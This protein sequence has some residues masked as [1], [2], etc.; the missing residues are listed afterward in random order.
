MKK[1]LVWMLVLVLL[2]GMTTVSAYAEAATEVTLWTLFTGDDG[3]TLQKI[4]DDFNASQTAVHLNHEAI[5]R[6]TLY[7]KLALSMS[8]EASL[9]DFFVTY[10]Y[11]VPYFA[12][13]DY[14][15]PMDET[16][17]AYGDFDFGFDKYHDACAQLNTFNG[18]R[19]CV[20]LDFPT[21]G[22]YAN[23]NLVN[24]YCPEVLEDD[25][26]TWDEIKAVGDKLKTDGVSD[27][28]VMVSSWA[29]ND[30]LASYLDWAGTYANEEGTEL[31]L[32]KEAAAEML[33]VWND[34]YN[35]GYLQQEGDDAGTLFATE[36]AIF[37]TGGTWNMTAINQYGFDFRFIA[38]PQKDT[39]G[40]PVL[41]GA[42]H[43]FM[44][45]KKNESAETQKGVSAF[46]HYFYEHS[47]DWASAGSIVAS[48]ATAASD[49]Y[50]AMAQA[51]V[52]NNYS[53][54]LPP[55][56]YSQLLFDV[57]DSLGYEAIFGHITP[58][59]YAETWE[60]QTIEK[61]NAQ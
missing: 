16:L 54:S 22:M 24:Q 18:K 56:T 45:P 21:W 34:C 20:S 9:P 29:R 26:V 8:D 38:G 5:D 51:F 53:I 12:K 35:A 25:V 15:Q 2:F 13:L 44:M 50:Q 27:I 23:M 28:K 61:V 60:K 1:T 41:F 59:D 42:S 11:D 48:K 31:S 10:S 37:F 19:Y 36:E 3:V 39:E 30:M 52:S 58:E 43:A 33:K 7:Q 14:I 57:C 32:N 55:Y 40:A 47:I 4:V 46:I 49:E 6:Q 17:A